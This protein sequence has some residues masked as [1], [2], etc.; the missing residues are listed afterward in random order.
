MPG[1]DVAA[2]L[3]ERKS[4]AE[5]SAEYLEMQCLRRAFL[6]AWNVWLGTG[7]SQSDVEQEA[8]STASAHR[9]ITEVSFLPE[10]RPQVRRQHRR[11]R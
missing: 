5:F 8:Y 1:Y 2:M 11:G 7:P 6:R 4:N 3:P 9:Q 10:P